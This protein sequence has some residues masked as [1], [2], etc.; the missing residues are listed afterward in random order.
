MNNED[1]FALW[2]P[3]ESRWSVW[4]KPVLFAGLIGS[5][6]SDST[7]DIPRVGR[8]P[9][10][11]DTAAVIDVPG[12][13]SVL[14][15]LALA[16]AGYRPVPLYNSSVAP[17]MLVNMN[18]VAIYLKLAIDVLKRCTIGADAP[19]V[20]LLNADRLDNAAGATVPGR[21]DNR[22]CV[23]PQDM[24]SA[25]FLKD[26]GITR[27][28]LLADS[29]KDDLAH[30]LYGYQDAGLPI[31][32]TVDFGIA[33]TPITVTKPSF[34][35]SALYRLEVYAGLRRNAAGGFGAVVPDP[36]SSGGGFG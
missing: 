33:P 4:A 22:W 6:L 8:F 27:V 32:R 10:P 20:F 18:A 21:Y 25:E 7:L 9:L 12:S 23:V 5:P 14:A 28:A 16:Q 30:V 31:A 36:S 19:P 26:A 34:Y 17:G 1:L 24:P 29:V 13:D 11:P 15:G 2:A 35:K 3:P